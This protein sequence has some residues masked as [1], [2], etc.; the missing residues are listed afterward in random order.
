MLS[1]GARQAVALAGGW[2][3]AS[4]CVAF[5]LI[6]FEEI[7][8]ATRGVLGVASPG[9]AVRGERMR[10]AAG[11]PGATGNTVELRAASNGHY[12]TSAEINGRSV[13]VMVDTGATMVALSWEDARRAGLYISD[14]DFSQAVRTANGVARVAPVMLDSIGIGGILVRNVPA[15]VSQPGMLG[16]SLL[17]MSFLQ[18]LQ[19]VDMRGGVLVLVE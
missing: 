2:L 7:K 11:R 3:F 15:A 14:R 5:S 18:R 16:T 6:Y 12:F 4:A 19:R 10:P 8:S 9:R 17:G 1:S 13:D